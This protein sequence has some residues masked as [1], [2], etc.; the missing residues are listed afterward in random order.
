MPEELCDLWDAA[1]RSVFE[2]GRLGPSSSPSRAPRGATLLLPAR[3]GGRAGRGG[4]GAYSASRTT[5]P[6]TNAT[7]RRCGSRTGGRTSSWRRSPTSCATR[8]PRSAT[9]SRSSGGARRRRR[10]TVE[11]REIDGAAARAHGPAGRR[12]ARRLP[13]QP[14]QDRAA[15]A[16][17]CRSGPCWTTPSRPAGPLIEAAGHELTVVLPDEPVWLDGDLTRLAQV[18]GNLLNNAAKYTPDGRPDPLSAGGRGGRGRHPGARQRDGHLGRDAPQGVRPVHPGGPDLDR[19]QGGLG[20][21]LSLVKKLVEMHGGTIAAESR[22]VGLGSMFT[23]RLPVAPPP[24]AP[25]ASPQAVAAVVSQCSTSA[26]WWWTTARIPQEPG[27]APGALE[28]PARASPMTGPRPSRPRQIPS[29][30]GLPRH[31]APRHGRA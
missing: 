23:V 27:D 30:R 16:R 17:R 13:H 2:S 5:S 6:T 29:A 26:S 11:A 24:A 20:I 1:L 14:R 21:G 22:G 31:R 28:S 7:R 12:P 25:A 18:V 10:P 4:R 9:V 15:S 8:S 3:A 19:A